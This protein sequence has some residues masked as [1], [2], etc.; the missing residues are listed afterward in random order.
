MTQ[1]DHSLLVKGYC[2]TLLGGLL[3]SVGGACGQVMFRSCGVTSNWLVPIRLFIGG[4]IHLSVA[5]IAGN[6]ALGDLRDQG[7]R[8][9]LLGF[10]LLG[11]AP[12]QYRS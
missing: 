10:S 8:A 1:P 4:L 7:A 12:C 9:P 5:A 11:A 3:W 6:K 2:M